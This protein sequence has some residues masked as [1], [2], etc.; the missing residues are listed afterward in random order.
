MQQTRKLIDLPS[1]A[2]VKIRAIS[3]FDFHSLPAELRKDGEAIDG[4]VM[5]RLILTRCTGKVR[6][7]ETDK[8]QIVDKHFDEADDLTEITIDELSQQDA[9]KIVTEVMALSPEKSE[10]KA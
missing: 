1:G 5:T 3:W 6:F 8:R 4:I 9:E 7:S 10:P 2:R